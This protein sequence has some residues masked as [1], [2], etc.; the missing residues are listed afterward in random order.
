MSS[1]NAGEIEAAAAQWLER[2]DGE[3]WNAAQQNDLDVWL[4]TSPRHRAAYWRLKAAWLQAE[5]LPALK[6]SMADRS[7]APQRERR[8]RP[9]VFRI[10]AAAAIIAMAG[11]AA[12]V[13]FAPPS[14]RLYA[15][16]IGE[17]KTLT[18][19]DGSKIELNTDT[20]LR[21]AIGNPRKVWLDRGEA[22]FQIK[23]DD[24]H[25]FL[26]IAGNHRVVD[27]GT[28]F[29]VRQ[30]AARIEVALVEGSARLE[31]TAPRA[32][33]PAIL[34][35]GDVAYATAEKISVV[36]Q[37]ERAITNALGWRHGVVIFDR[38]TLADAAAE[39]NR[40]NTK[41]IVILDPAAARLTIHGRFPSNDTTAIVNV[42]QDVFGLRVETNGNDILIS[43]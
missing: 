42:A 25:P 40:Y 7:T 32:P 9:F 26:V 11:T 1:P 33:T 19:A 16:A 37:P 27:L 14:T 13:H 28:K 8:L 2:C 23:H 35:P 12:A 6:P 29:L 4:A 5:R 30:D 15:T 20:S 41:Q 36:K 34:K 39:L 24:T 43:R 21:V 22:F 31:S 10:A 18:L 3:G 17:R 38:T